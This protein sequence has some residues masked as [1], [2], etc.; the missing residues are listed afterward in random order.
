GL[1]VGTETCAR[2]GVTVA[3][4]HIHQV[5]YGTATVPSG[6]ASLNE[7]NQQSKHGLGF[8][9]SGSILPIQLVSLGAPCCR[10]RNA[11]PAVSRAGFSDKHLGVRYEHGLVVA[12]PQC[13]MEVGAS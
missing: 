8:E 6:Y 3:F 5:T 9:D 10:W 7:Y 1:Q 12:I 4:W 13:A 2:Q 11:F